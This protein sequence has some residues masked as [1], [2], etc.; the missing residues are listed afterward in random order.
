MGLRGLAQLTG[1]DAGALEAEAA[2]LRR[3]RGHQPVE[4][5]LRRRAEMLLPGDDASAH[6]CRAEGRDLTRIPGDA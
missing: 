3:R 1:E 2:P 6:G 5:V 4:P